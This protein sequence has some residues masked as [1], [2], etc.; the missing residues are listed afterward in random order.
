MATQA[1]R[2]E[3]VLGFD[4]AKSVLDRTVLSEALKEINEER[5]KENKA[6]AKEQ[7]LKAI[8]L[9]SKMEAARKQFE[10]QQKKFEKELGKI[11]NKIE[12][13][14]EGREPPEDKDGDHHSD[15]EKCC[16]GDGDTCC[17]K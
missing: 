6:K 1:E 12:A 16:D 9:R 11:L 10:G 4:P 15:K 3:S 7:I 2:L 5:V 13:M 8:E 14:A 17:V